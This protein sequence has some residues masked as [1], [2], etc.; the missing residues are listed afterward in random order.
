MI[1]QKGFW[2]TGKM[3]GKRNIRLGINRPSAW[4][5][6]ILSLDYSNLFLLNST[7]LQSQKQPVAQNSAP[8]SQSIFLFLCDS[9][10]N[11]FL[12]VTLFVFSS[13]LTHSQILLLRL[14][15]SKV[16]KNCID[17][18]AGL[19]A[20]DET[21]ADPDHDRLFSGHFLCPSHTHLVQCPS[22]NM[23]PL[24]IDKNS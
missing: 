17:L 5:F 8:P 14:S 1:Y 2:F 4:E 24:G 15:N 13:A 22:D 11:E 16:V 10:C 23:T 19:P 12:D 18:D 21:N 9:K 20:G 3:G 6:F 7:H